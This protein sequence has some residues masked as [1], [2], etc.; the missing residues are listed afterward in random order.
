MFMAQKD[1]ATHIAE[2][3]ARL[4]VKHP[5]ASTADIARVVLN[6][7][8]GFDDAKVREFIPLLVER[9]SRAVLTHRQT[10]VGTLPITSVEERDQSS[11]TIRYTVAADTPSVAAM[12]FTGS[13]EACIRLARS[14]L[15]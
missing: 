4:A 9:E 7:Y 12:V 6:L 5:V 13:P 15:D 3:V 1:E 8:A 11:A 10:P 2:I 14:A